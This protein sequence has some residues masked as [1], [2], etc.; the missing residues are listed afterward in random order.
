MND[1]AELFYTLSIFFFNLKWQCKE[2]KSW[3]KQHP[4]LLSSSFT[5]VPFPT[6]LSLS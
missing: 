2:T 3:G 6:L 5:P 1:Q 4:L